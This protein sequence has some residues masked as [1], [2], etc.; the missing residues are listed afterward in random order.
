MENTQRTEGIAAE[1]NAATYVEAARQGKNDWWRYLLGL[2]IILVAWLLV[3]SYASAF[4]ANALAGPAGV[5]AY[6]A[7]DFSAIGPVRGFVVLVASFLVFLAAILLVVSLIHRR[8]P[9]TLITA[10]ER[11]DWRRVGQGFVAWFVPS[12]LVSGLGMYLF[13]PD[14]FSFTPDLAAFAVFVPLALVLTALQTTT[15]ELFFRGYLVQGASRIWANRI[16]LALV[17]AVL[18]AVPHLGNPEASAGGWLTIFFYYFLGGGLVLAAVSLVDGT[19][20]LAIGA[21]FANNIFAFF[22]VNQVG[23]VITTPALFTVNTY[24]ATFSAL[25]IPVIVPLFLA[26]AYGVFKR[27]ALTRSTEPPAGSPTTPSNREPIGN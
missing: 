24:H 13:Y 15:E 5:A 17:S 27:K 4:V 2:V 16:F 22:V 12:S 23:S 8:H 9:R 26:I 21:H 19:T 11:I 18:F 3:G 10:R 25:T 6:T 7:Q 14:S 20:E 1:T